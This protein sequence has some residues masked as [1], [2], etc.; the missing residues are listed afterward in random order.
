MI[1][2]LQR[3]K[4]MHPSGQHV[5]DY[6]CACTNNA[7]L[8]TTKNSQVAIFKSYTFKTHPTVLKSKTMYTTQ[9]CFSELLWRETVIHTVQC[10]NYIIPYM[11]YSYAEM[12]KC[13]NAQPSERPTFTK[14]KVRFETMLLETSNYLQFTSITLE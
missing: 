2:S 12:M 5:H 14:L 11:C 4:I 7:F 8:E 10:I 9:S 1:L 13:W 3:V 6:A